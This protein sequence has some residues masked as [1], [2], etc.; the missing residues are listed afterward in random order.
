M[1]DIVHAGS[2]EGRNK[3]TWRSLMRELSRMS[4]NKLD[5]QAMIYCSESGEVIEIKRL[6]TINGDMAEEFDLV[7]CDPIGLA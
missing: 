1:Y 3:M 5:G 7:E 6:T 2:M 4:D